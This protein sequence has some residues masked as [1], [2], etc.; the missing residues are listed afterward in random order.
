MSVSIAYRNKI[1]QVKTA[2]VVR[3]LFRTVVEFFAQTGF[4]F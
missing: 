4:I 3:R 2:S 1:R